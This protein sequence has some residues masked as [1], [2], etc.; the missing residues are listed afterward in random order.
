MVGF[1]VGSSLSFVGEAEIGA[2]DSGGAPDTSAVDR[3]YSVYVTPHRRRALRNRVIPGGDLHVAAVGEVVTEQF[4][5]PIRPKRPLPLRHRGLVEGDLHVAAA[6][7]TDEG[8]WAPIVAVARAQKTTVLFG[9]SQDNSDAAPPEVVVDALPPSVRPRRQPRWATPHA[10]Q[11]DVHLGAPPA[12]DHDHVIYTRPCR[13]VPNRLYRPLQADL[14][15]AV[16]PVPFDH[17]HGIYARPPRYPVKPK[18][19]PLQNDLH[20]A[21]FVPD[22]SGDLDVGLQPHPR[23]RIV[24]SRRGPIDGDLHVDAAPQPEDSIYSPV[25][26]RRRIS[27]ARWIPPQGDL[28]VAVVSDGQDNDGYP[29]IRPRRRNWQTPFIGNIA[30][31]SAPSDDDGPVVPVVPPV[32]TSGGWQSGHEPRRRP[33]A[34]LLPDGQ[35]LHPDT[36]DEYNDLL[37]DAM[38]RADAETARAIAEANG[39]VFPPD[40]PT[41]TLQAT[42]ELDADEEQALLLILAA[43]V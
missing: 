35:K 36:W 26:T 43:N 13:R 14:T 33:P 20:T 16:P 15:T 5:P 27:R 7:D 4:L 6:A 10:I 39:V 42:D 40:A 21:G 22:V 11:S 8:A 3:D 1:V 37:A 32:I 29:A 17:D 34:I 19:G 25:R 41:A 24:Q 12:E 23:R 18:V 28:H 2:A 9:R 30:W 31:L 38:R